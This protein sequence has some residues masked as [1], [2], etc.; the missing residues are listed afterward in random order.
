[1]HDFDALPQDTWI[2]VLSKHL[3]YGIH[4][5]VVVIIITGDDITFNV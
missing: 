4:I 5:L 2:W 3:I 1:M